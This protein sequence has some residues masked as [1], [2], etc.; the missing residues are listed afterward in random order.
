MANTSANAE[1]FAAEAG[2][3]PVVAGADAPT[4]TT[5][6]FNTAPANKFY[7][8]EDLARTR[9]Q[10]KDKL[11]PQIDK[12]K[13]ELE[14][15]K[16]VQA[17]KDAAIAAEEAAREAERAEKAKKKQEEEMELRDLLKAKETEWNEQLERERQ[18]RERAFALLE[19]EK[20]FAEVQ[21][22][23][24]TRIEQVRDN[25]IPEL[26]DLI[27]GNTIEEIDASIAGLQERSSRILESAQQAMQSAR[28]DMTGTRVTAPQA[29]PL[30]INTGNRQFTAEE[31]A[32]MPMNEYVK[33]RQQL[34]SDK[35]RG[36]TQG[37]FG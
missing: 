3:T 27:Q 36:R 4:A 10:E 31:I 11:Y 12:L 24:Q 32:A 22:Y 34:L 16:R 30:D 14:A 2:A 35:A 21:N 1:A 5:S 37:L 9:A 17:E 15:L 19:R 29:G 28:R 33:Y 7:T 20:T 26:V 23:R 13:E 18:E 8:E 6:T 25:I